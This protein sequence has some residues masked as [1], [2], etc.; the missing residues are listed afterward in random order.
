MIS[1]DG[2]SNDLTHVNHCQFVRDVVAV[3]AVV[4]VDS[5]GHDHPSSELGV[6]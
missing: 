1:P 6:N 2:L 3:A 5:V 4:L